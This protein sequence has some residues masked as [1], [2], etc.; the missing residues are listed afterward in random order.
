MPTF[1]ICSNT[2]KQLNSF[3]SLT[4]MINPLRSDINYYVLPDTR[5]YDFKDSVV[6]DFPSLSDSVKP[7]PPNSNVF[8][9]INLFYKF[10]TF[11]PDFRIQIVEYVNGNENVL[12]SEK[13][14]LSSYP[15]VFNK[16][17]DH[18]FV[19]SGNPNNIKVRLTKN[20]LSSNTVTIKKNSFYTIEK[21]YII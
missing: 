18:I 21:K 19:S 2:T 14:G 3:S 1:R 7:I 12:Y 17:Y 10:E 6:L 16:L 5:T 15:N 11:S 20:D 8:I 9:T 13:E 4:N